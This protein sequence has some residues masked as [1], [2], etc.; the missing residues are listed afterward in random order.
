NG[1]EI[2]RLRLIVHDLGNRGIPEHLITPREEILKE[3]ALLHYIKD[4]NLP[5]ETDS[6]ATNHYIT[7]VLG[8]ITG[9]LLLVIV[10][11]S[12]NELLVY[13]RNHQSV[14]KGFPIAFMKKVT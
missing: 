6:F 1:L 5:I 9:L 14:L 7:N 3:D 8:M 10:L 12:G 13:E 4:N 11:I 2:N